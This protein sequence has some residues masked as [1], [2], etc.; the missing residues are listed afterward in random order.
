VRGA[1]LIQP[2]VSLIFEPFRFAVQYSA[3]EG[4]FTNFGAFRD[5][6]QISFVFSY[7]LN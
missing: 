7:L 4:A 5:R 6:D 1:W 2:S 3:I